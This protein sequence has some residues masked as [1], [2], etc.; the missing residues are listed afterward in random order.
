MTLSE[1][2]KKSLFIFD[3]DGT[4]VHSDELHNK[5][6]RYALREILNDFDYEKLKGLST[7]AAISSL[8]KRN[9]IYISDKRKNQIIAD[10]QKYAKANASKLIKI[11]TKLQIF[12]KSLRH[13]KEIKTALFTCGSRN[14]VNASLIPLGMEDLFDYRVYAED[15][16][17]CKPSPEGIYKIISYFSI[18]PKNVIVLEDAE[19]GFESARRANVDYVDVT[20]YFKNIND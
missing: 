16:I 11:N 17:E 14:T 1:I 12:L 20:K 13:K 5:A 7:D 4:L 10:K 19:N 8:L 9:Q 18:D 2:S 3:Y 15:V 6:F